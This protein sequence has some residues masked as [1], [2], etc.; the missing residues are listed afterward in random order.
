MTLYIVL[1]RSHFI[2]H[3]E[4]LMIQVQIIE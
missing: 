3:E 2:Y 1:Q 4:M